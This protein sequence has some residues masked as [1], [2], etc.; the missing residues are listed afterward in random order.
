MGKFLRILLVFSFI[1]LGYQYLGDEVKEKFKDLQ[2]RSYE[3]INPKGK[4]ADLLQDLD[5]KIQS[6][7][8]IK[9]KLEKIDIDKITDPEIKE[10]ISEIKEKASETV[11]EEINKLVEKIEELNEK[12]GPIT[13]V[14]SKIV[15]KVFPD[16]SP[17]P[18]PDSTSTPVPTSTSDPTST[19]QNQTPTVTPQG[20][21]PTPTPTN[22][23]EVDSTPTPSSPPPDPQCNWVCE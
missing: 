16:K 14:I 23:N 21:T 15:E 3:V 18:I 12:E 22:E 4:R 9:E 20:Q 2:A 13:K 11:V 10:I 8:E 17:T 5:L 1:W 7:G 6:I 19:P